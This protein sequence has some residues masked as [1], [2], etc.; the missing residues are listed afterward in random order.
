MHKRSSAIETLVIQRIPR[1]GS[2]INVPREYESRLK[3]APR[4]DGIPKC[5]GSDIG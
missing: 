4:F 3:A 2:T 5:G 1:H